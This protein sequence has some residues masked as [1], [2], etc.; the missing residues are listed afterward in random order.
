M[1]IDKI[2]ILDRIGIEDKVLDVGG[3]VSFFEGK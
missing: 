1:K 3:Y 2:K